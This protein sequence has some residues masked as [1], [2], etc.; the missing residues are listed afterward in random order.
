VDNLIL[1]SQ[2][3]KEVYMPDFFPYTSAAPDNFKASLEAADSAYLS[4][5]GVVSS[6][7]T[8]LAAVVT[9]LSVTQL[10]LN[11][12]FTSLNIN[13]GTVVSTNVLNVLIGLTGALIIALKSIYTSKQTTA[14]T[15]INS[16]VALGV[17]LGYFPPQFTGL[18]SIPQNANTLFTYQTDANTPATDEQTA[19]ANN[20]MGR[21]LTAPR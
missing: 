16:Q 15:T 2:P 3:I 18:P 10:A 11:N 12:T 14:L 19:A 5:T 1:C 17:K 8:A 20:V 9:T 7:P 4:A 6:S 21:Y 13:T